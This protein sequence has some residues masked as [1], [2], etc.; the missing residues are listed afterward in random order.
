MTYRLIISLRQFYVR[1]EQ[2]TKKAQVENDMTKT[3]VAVVL[4]FMSCQ[5]LNPVR[6]ILL[7]VL[8]SSSQ[9]CGFFPF[10][11]GP[12]TSLALTLDAASHFFVYSLCNKQLVKDEVKGKL[13]IATNPRIRGRDAG[14]ATAMS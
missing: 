10:Y 2:V 8:P 14:C 13:C 1:R 6:R 3:L 11:F 5:L 12:L 7:E 4:I 9:G